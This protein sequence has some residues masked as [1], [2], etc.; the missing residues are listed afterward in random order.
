M[1]TQ[2]QKDQERWQDQ[3]EIELL[4]GLFIALMLVP[5]LVVLVRGLYA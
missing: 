1:K 3:A 2:Y 4:L 5:L